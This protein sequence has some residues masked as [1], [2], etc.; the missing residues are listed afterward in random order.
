MEGV[1]VGRFGVICWIGTATSQHVFLWDMC[2]LGS[3]GITEGLSK[4]LTDPKILKIT[5]DCR[6]MSDAFLHKYNVKLENVFD[7]QVFPIP[8]NN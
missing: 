8:S 4:I 2:S 7:T 1:R 6:Y 3:P 5:H